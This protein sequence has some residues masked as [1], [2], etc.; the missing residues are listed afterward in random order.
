MAQTERSE[1]IAQADGPHEL[2]PEYIKDSKLFREYLQRIA[3]GRDMHCI[4]TASSETG[5]GKTTLAVSLA[6]LWDQH[7][8]TADKAAV[9]D[10][11]EYA[12]K[13]DRLPPGSV[14]I[15]DEAEK[16]ADSRRSNTHGNVD[17]SQAFAAKRFRQIFGILTAPSK[18]WVDKRLGASSADYWIQA[19]EG[20]GGSIKGEAKVYRM[21]EQEHYETFYTERTETISWPVLDNDPAFKELDKIKK[22]R[23]SGEVESNYV[24]KNEVEDM[25]ENFWNKATKKARFEI[26]RAMSDDGLTQT[27]I[28]DIITSAKGVDSLT[29]SGV[30]RMVNSE[31][32]EDFY[33][34]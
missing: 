6:L 26:V 23:L 27:R 13:Y 29:Q 31:S 11:P 20:D 32:F 17:V 2:W 10:A 34:T 4:V 15:L 7:G 22:D 30:S 25:R 1:R 14:L 24:H 12:Y 16:A 5:V 18:S 8:W 21:K 19:Q 28:A 3:N 33:T 9:A